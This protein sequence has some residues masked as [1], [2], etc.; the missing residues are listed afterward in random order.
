MT[1]LVV[2][3]L[4]AVILAASPAAAADLIYKAPVAAPAPIEYGNL[5][6]GVDA[7]T[8][9]G[10]AGYAGVLYA[11]TGMGT[12]GIRLSAFG[13]YGKYQYHDESNLF[14][15]RF[16]SVDALI[17][18][19]HVFS[20]GAITTAIGVNYQDQRVKPFDPFNPVQGSVAGFKIQQDFWVNPTERT[21]VVGIASYSTAFRTYYSILRGGYDFFGKGF[22]IGPE[23]GALGNE[24]T[25]QFRLGA[26]LT[27]LQVLSNAK[28]AISG[29]WLHERSEREGAYITANLD[30]TF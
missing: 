1:R 10:L 29:G 24:R 3:S 20:N 27:G 25:D 13:L 11:P 6:F 7:N 23:V 22:F 2:A 21:L 8:N 14:Q 18:W 4:A 16:A 5:Y 17:G 15:G 26:V 9:H 19:S 30:F 12:S 28:L